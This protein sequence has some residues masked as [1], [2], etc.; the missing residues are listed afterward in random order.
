MIYVVGLGPGEAVQMTPKALA[1]IEAS[2]IVAGYTVYMELVAE[3]VKDKECISTPMMGELERCRR[4]VLAAKEGKTVAVISSG[5]AGIYGMASLVL[6]LIEEL[7]A[8]VEVEV[9][10]G[11]TAASS[12]AAVL[13]APLT[14]D[15]AVISLSNLLTPWEAIEKRL[16][17]AAQAGFA[18]AIYNPC[19]KKRHDFLEKA[20]NILLKHLSPSTVCGYVRNIGRSGEESRVLSLGELKDCKLDMFTTVIIGNSTTKAINGRMVTPR[21]YSLNER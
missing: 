5:D 2:Q 14:H 6:E 15:F 3:L 21:G 10:A 8:D 12:A 1:A 7:D 9:V 13:G 17:L 4:A 19:S 16:D 11:I 18:L 20:C